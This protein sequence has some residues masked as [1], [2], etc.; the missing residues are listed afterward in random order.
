MAKIDLTLRNATNTAEFRFEIDDGDTIGDL[1]LALLERLDLPTPGRAGLIGGLYPAEARRATI[2]LSR[3]GVL[4]PERTMDSYSFKAGALLRYYFELKTRVSLSSV[5]LVGDRALSDAGLCIVLEWQD[6][7]YPILLPGSPT[8]QGQ[9]EGSLLNYAVFRQM[10]D[11]EG[12][13]KGPDWLGDWRYLNGRTHSL[14]DPYDSQT[15]L[16]E[17]FTHGDNVRLVAPDEVVLLEDVSEQIQILDEIV[18]IDEEPTQP[19][20]GEETR[21]PST[22]VR[23]RSTTVELVQGDITKQKTD[24]IVN[25]ANQE[26]AVG[27]GVDG[28]IHRAAGPRLSRATRGLAPC[29]PGTAVFTPGFDLPASW[30]IHTVGPI[31]RRGRGE[32]SDIL[33]RAY[34]SSL[35]LAIRSRLDSIAFPSISTGVYG[36]PLEKAAQVAMQATLNTLK[37]QDQLSLVRF[38]LYSDTDYEAY[39]KALAKHE[40]RSN[41][42]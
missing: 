30:V 5:N 4:H 22:S 12:R 15:P 3:H 11:I 26:L 19:P 25:A 34:A 27:G 39:C 10:A 14:V 13:S 28:A 18:L 20:A 29:Q 36:Y 31:Y 40:S 8:P 23:I 7:R 42:D 1:L 24:V 17:H 9:I 21:G 38:V 2:Y 33:A 16:G 32:P 37:A 41:D 6:R 35:N